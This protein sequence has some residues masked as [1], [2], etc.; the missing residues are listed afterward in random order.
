MKLNRSYTFSLIFCSF[1]LFPFSSAYGANAPDLSTQWFSDGSLN[2]DGSHTLVKE[3]KSSDVKI[4]RGHKD[5]HSSSTLESYGDITHSMNL[6][7]GRN[8]A[9]QTVPRLAQGNSPKNAPKKPWR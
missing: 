2:V 8:T 5:S 7:P 9:D 6:K 3:I 1:I 4:N